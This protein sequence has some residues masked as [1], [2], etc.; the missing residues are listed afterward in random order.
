MTKKSKNSGASRLG[1]PATS[2]ASH[3]VLSFTDAVAHKVMDPLLPG[4]EEWATAAGVDAEEASWLAA[5]LLDFFKNYAKS[6]PAP[7][8]TNL[9]VEMSTLLLESAGR[10]H[11][12]MRVSMA[13]ALNSF[14][15]F[16][17]TTLAWTGTRDA[18]VEL[19][20]ITGRDS[21]APPNPKLAAYVAHQSLEPT[22]AGADRA[23]R[24][25]VRWA[26]ALLEWI[27]TGRELTPAGAVRR[28]DIAGAAACVDMNAV[29][30][31]T[32]RA[33]Q[34]AGAPVPVTSMTAL[35]RLMQYWQA[36]IDTRLIK[37][38][39]KR[40]TVTR[41]GQTFRND[42][43][44]ALNDTAVLAYFLYCD[45]IIP[46]PGFNP[47]ES[48]MVKTARALATAASNRPDSTDTL[49]AP[50]HPFAPGDVQAMMV[51]ASLRRLAA[52]GLVEMGT[53][54]TVPPSLRSAL[55][56]A[57]ELLDDEI[58]AAPAST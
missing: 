24:T 13:L 45:A 47:D 42:P 19:L 18:L 57:L 32:S 10:F 54:I 30:A 41:S 58:D 7:D 44:G 38:A 37:T 55:A 4:F 25:Y 50:E 34:P 17:L 46:Y 3:Q 36:L 15:K 26:A 23:T 33:H 28:K 8:A 11:P 27:G 12:E 43:A 35:P 29:G 51:A 40:V 49:L 6:V 56:S 14:L 53:H 22:E 5:L 2:A 21:M 48:T 16:L 9:D 31:A 52:T 20:D 1:N 39:G